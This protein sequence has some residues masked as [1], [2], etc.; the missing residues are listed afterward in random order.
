MT[1]THLQKLQNGR[2]RYQQQRTILVNKKIKQLACD[3]MKDIGQLS[4][5]E[6]FIAGVVLYWAEGF[7]HPEESGLGLATSDPMMAKFYI[8]FLEVCFYIPKD[9][10]RL[11]VTAN[12]FH[13]HRISEIQD[14][15]SDCLDI[16]Q[17][18]FSKPF[19][20]K[21]AQQKKF[22]NEQNYHGVIRIH[23]SK[24]LDMLRKMRGWLE[25]VKLSKD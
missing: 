23:V 7:K 18:S 5:R 14:F 3:G 17:K 13:E 11:R 9:R 15:W 16:P 2:K 22:P 1:K 25:G 12:I 19:F 21:V 4:N 20:Q 6:L 10:L 24:S 8:R